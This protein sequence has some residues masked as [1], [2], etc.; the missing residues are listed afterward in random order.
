MPKKT[1]HNEQ[2]A[3]F[4]WCDLQQGMYP[5][6]AYI[7]AVPNGGHRHKAVAA[8][9]KAEGAKAGVPDICFPV[10]RGG[11]HGLW[12]ETKVGKNKTT[13]SQEDWLEF[14]DRQGYAVAVCYGFDELVETTEW[15]LELEDK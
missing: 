8:R 9:M 12:M 11:Y 15:Y 14:L 13:A 2:A 4:S 7:F 3:F 10:P 6:L 1:E 5:E